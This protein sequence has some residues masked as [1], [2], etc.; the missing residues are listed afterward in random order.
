MKKK[1]ILSILKIFFII[2]GVWCFDFLTTIFALNFLIGTEE[3][4]FI[5][6]YFYSL[7]FKGYLFM[8]ILVGI[9][10]LFLSLFLY[11]N[12]EYL[13]KK[14]KNKYKDILLTIGLST[15]LLLEL[16]CVINNIILI[17]KLI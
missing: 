6:R 8:F 2:F 17:I 15:F 9:L 12:N 13:K 11:K 16:G 5:S 3:S 10:S 1:K 14:Y 4:N 7:G